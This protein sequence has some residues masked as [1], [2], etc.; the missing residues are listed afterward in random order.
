ME[1]INWDMKKTMILI[2]GKDK[3][4][5]I[6]SIEEL[7]TLFKYKIYYKTGRY[8][9]LDFDDVNILRNPNE[10]KLNNKIVYKN[11]IALHQPK[12]A[13]DFGLRIRICSSKGNYYT[14]YP[15]TINI[16]EN[17]F[18]KDCI[19]QVL[20]YLKEI[21]NFFNSKSKTDDFLKSA[22]NKLSFIHP[23]S[24][25]NSYLSDCNIEKRNLEMNYTIFPFQFNLSQKAALE[26]A[27]SHSI[28]IIEGPPG[29]GKTQ[30]ILNILSNLIT[31]QGKSVAVVSNNN[32]AIKNVKDKLEKHG[33]GFLT[34]LLG[35]K[36]NKDA[37]FNDM[38]LP[39]V[40]SWSY[41]DNPAYLLQNIMQ[42]HTQLSI[43]MGKE[44]K[45]AQLT[46]EL[47]EWQLEQKHFESY[48]SKQ[49]LDSI[50]RLPRF[51]NN[52]D[53]ILSFLAET[54]IA[55]KYEQTNK[56]I[57]KLKL[58]F[59]YGI[60]DFK[61][62]N[63]EET[64]LLLNLQKNFYK[65]QIENF[66]NQIN[67]LTSELQNFSYDA[68]L[69]ELQQLSE[70]VFQIYLYQSHKDMPKPI[71]SQENYKRYF[72]DFIKEYPIILSTTYTLLYSIP[73]NYLLDYVIIDEASQVDLITGIL[74]LS[75]CR[76]VIIVGD[77]KQL[78]NIVDKSIESK[79]QTVPQ[80]QGYDYFNH[81]LISSVIQ[82]YGS[83]IPCVT[84]REHYRCHPDIIE[85]CNQKYYNG[86][87]IPYTEA[88]SS[89]ILPLTVYRTA[90]GN[91]MRKVTRGP[92][93]GTYN[94]RELDVIKEILRNPNYTPVNETL[95][96]ITPYRKQAD[97]AQELVGD[98]YECDTIH[99]YQG[100][101]MDTIIMSTVLDS[102]YTAKRGINFVN[103]PN[104]IN[105]AVSRAIKHFVLVTD[106][107][108]F[109]QE[110]GEIPDLIRYIQYRSLDKA[111]IDSPIVSVFDLLYTQ[112]SS[113][114]L[115]LKA[116]MDS[117][118]RWQSEEGIR[119]LLEE[120]ISKEPYNL[121]NYKQQILIRNL[122][123]DNSKLTEEEALYVNNRA[124][125]DFV[126]FRKLDKACVF[127]I[128]VDGFEFHENNPKQQYKDSL[129]N[130][131]LQ[132]MDIPL[133]RLATNGSGNKEKIIHYL[134]SCGYRNHTH[135]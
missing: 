22:L 108:L 73:E 96:I 72:K 64:A 105:V 12:Y 88:D 134:N 24:V 94:Q 115:P 30:T 117:K 104:M 33:Y 31:I 55:R 100:R 2:N 119:V 23:D 84:L 43:M 89:N 65:I 132:K 41:N 116:K 78:S 38:P 1:P 27:L 106:H 123:I 79:I 86:D 110:K 113:K 102:S 93:I 52:P 57:Y 49:D 7:S 101:E 81:N 90:E 11:G 4:E 36:E 63:Q 67:I 83:R 111:I 74:T 35:N 47:R 56:I 120:I 68:L 5:E 60:F 29:T 129:K 19:Q 34:A 10:I 126:I 51:Y 71:F 76:N 6:E 133:L 127:V 107:E 61:K 97:K 80:H 98:T 42:L 59:K 69:K 17:Q 48:Y 112:Y 50:H 26:N 99:K 3:T 28:S 16:V 40:D 8:A 13:L 14:N 25:L 54:S 87:L 92:Q 45:K 37:F 131:I 39:Q 135:L 15:K 18:S 53:K 58:F 70:K 128:E 44:R 118:A 124:S 66:E 130:S 121:F 9:I 32:P 114:L 21:A 122:L 125:L 91:H 103:N 109:F 46:Q 95:G 75:C 20:N 62:L 77:T 85:F 82:L